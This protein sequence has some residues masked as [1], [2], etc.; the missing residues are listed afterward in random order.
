M[1]SVR[2]NGIQIEYDTFGSSRGEPILLV[3]GLGA[4]MLLW[5]EEFCQRLADRGHFVIRFDNRDVG[6][7]TWFDAHGVPNIPQLMQDVQSGKAPSTA[8][9]LDDMA[10]D[11]VGLCDAL[12]LARAHFVG[13]S[14]GGMIAQTIAYRHAPRVAS[15]TSIMS[16][17][18]SPS[19]PQ[20]K[21]EVVGR[22]MMPPPATRQAAIDQSVE[23][24]KVISGK[25]Y[26]FDE[27]AVRERTG[28]LYDRANH[29]QGQARQLAAIMA[30][31]DRSPR[32][33]GVRAP[34]LVIH[35]E[36]DPLVPVEGGKHTHASIPGSEILLVPGMGHDLP[37]P[38]FG[39]L[40]EAISTHVK[41][42]AARS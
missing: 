15:L 38:L 8:Y 23:T 32:L 26:P 6:L 10:D 21:P 3:M 41:K 7:S 34:T 39:K 17:T 36:D 22:L 29:P 37:K 4:Q 24:W 25:G 42:A 28:L 5:D 14:M 16:S 9:S 27:A 11:A 33:T 31:G 19:V 40:V 2:A 18:G 12:S 35:G 1:T 13:A 30:H 20:A